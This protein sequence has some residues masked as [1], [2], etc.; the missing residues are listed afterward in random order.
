MKTYKITSTG[1]GEEE[2]RR[3]GGKYLEKENTLLRGGTVVVSI[4]LHLLVLGGTWSEQTN[5]NKKVMT[6]VQTDK[7]TEYPLLDLNPF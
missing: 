5:N 6:D 1:G 3:K 2:R 7:Q 4:G